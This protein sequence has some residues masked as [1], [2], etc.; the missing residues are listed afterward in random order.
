MTITKKIALIIKEALQ[1]EEE[2]EISVPSE[3]NF[4][5]FSTNLALKL[6]KELKKNPMELARELAEKIKVGNA[7]IFLKIEVREPGFINFWATKDFLAKQVLVGYK[8]KN[9]FGKSDLG[10]KQAVIVEYSSPN[11]AKPMHVGHLRSTIIG[12][13]IANIHEFLPLCGS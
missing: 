7:D 1:I 10:K 3:K 2:V 8:N 5:N 12:D 6:A 9:N 11:I 13:A 4:G